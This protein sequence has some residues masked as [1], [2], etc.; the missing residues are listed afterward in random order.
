VQLVNADVVLV[1][2]E[3]LA[4]LL[5][6]ACILVFLGVLGR[7]LLPLPGVLPALMASF[8]YFELRCFGADTM[9]ASTIWPP[10]A[11]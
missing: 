2:I 6:S 11:M 1:A 4:V 9:V 10:R 5:G 3:A 7:F 8:S